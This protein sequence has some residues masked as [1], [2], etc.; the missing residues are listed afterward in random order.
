MVS[1]VIH[2][3]SLCLCA[4]AAD[5]MASQELPEG[6]RPCPRWRLRK[7]NWSIPTGN[8]W[9]KAGIQWIRR[10]RCLQYINDCIEIKD[11]LMHW[12]MTAVPEFRR[13]NLWCLLKS[14]VS[15]N[16][17]TW[18][19]LVISTVQHRW[20]R[21]RRVPVTKFAHKLWTETIWPFGEDSMD[22]P[23]AKGKKKNSPRR[24]V[25]LLET[26]VLSPIPIV[27][28]CIGIRPTAQVPDACRITASWFSS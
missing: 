2:P 24:A 16:I 1:G 4:E 22:F 28:A 10:K 7:R 25:D 15:V 17:I 19:I 11:L 21:H 6:Q 27:G 26:W 18:I 12:T 14:L 8:M 9:Q 20:G 13:K 5:S 23:M 3:N